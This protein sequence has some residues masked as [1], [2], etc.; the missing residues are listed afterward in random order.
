MPCFAGAKDYKQAHGTKKV[1]Y[2]YSVLYT[3]V[4]RWSSAAAHMWYLA[5]AKDYKQAHGTGGL[6]CN[7]S[8]FVIEHVWTGGQ[9]S[10]L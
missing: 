10:A 7:Y 3:C 5:G 8:W 4:D 6:H 2:N 9:V 1:H